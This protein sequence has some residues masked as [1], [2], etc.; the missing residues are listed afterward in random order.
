MDNGYEDIATRTFKFAV[1]VIKLISGLPFNT[2]TKV[3]GSQIIRSVTSINS[4]IVE[5]RAALT[6]KE[7]AYHYNVS[8]KE[9]KETQN[10][11]KMFEA[12]EIILAE[13]L[14]PFHKE[15]A[16]IVAILVTICKTNSK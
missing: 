6:K 11:L 10:W 8:K 12:S 16:E 3:L 13:K 14:Q 1:A 2:A 15:I 5:A 7:F 4:N 9:A